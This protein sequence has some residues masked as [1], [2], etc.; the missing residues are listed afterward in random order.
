V[1]KPIILCDLDGTLADCSHRLP[2]ICES[3]NLSPKKDRDWRG[4]FAACGKDKPIK[5][6][7]DFLNVFDRYVV[8]VWITSGRSDECLEQTEQ[9]LLAHGVV[10]DRLIM[11]K[12]GD[13]TDD[14]I[15]KPRWLDDGTIPRER[16]MLAL[17][18]RNRVV[19]AWRANGVPC[20]QVAAG[21]F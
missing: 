12:A 18:D 21:N 13:H 1:S 3:D 8:E 15:L 7:I 20:L 9:W 6:M 17:D 16:V 19:E 2:Y 10:Y 11:R 5:H 14:G 4:F